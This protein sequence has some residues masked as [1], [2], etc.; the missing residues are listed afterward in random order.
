MGR[1]GG[2]PSLNFGA[3]LAGN[4]VHGTPKRPTF[5]GYSNSSSPSKAGVWAF[6]TIWLWVKLTADKAL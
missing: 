5:S 2:R 6:V 1:H 3:L 4:N